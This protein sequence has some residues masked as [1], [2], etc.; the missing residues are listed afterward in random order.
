MIKKMVCETNMCAGCN[1]C[2]ELCPTNAIKIHDNLESYNALI[3]PNQCIECNICH[4]HCPMKN[5]LEGQEPKQWYQGWANDCK[6]R[7]MGSSGGLATAIS[8]YFLKEGGV[9]YSCIL[10][11]GEFI[12]DCIEENQLGQ[13]S[14]SKYVKSNP[15]GI[16]KTIAS[17]LQKQ[18]KVLFVGLPCQ[19]AALKKY[20]NKKWQKDLYTID[21]ICHGT[22]SPKLLKN[23][24]DNYNLDIFTS[25]DIKFRDKQQF[26]L[27]YDD[28]SIEKEKVRD[29]YT[30]A[31]LNGLIYTENCYK[32]PY[33]TLKRVSDLTLGDSWGTNLS[34]IEQKKGISLVLSMT[35]KGDILLKNSNLFLTSVDLDKAILNNDQLQEPSK[36]PVKRREFFRKLNTKNFNHLVFKL[37]PNQCIKQFIKVILIKLHLI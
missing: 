19:V 7:A 8:K 20:I 6:V 32:C 12:F 17:Q 33:A 22:P 15:Y 11:D 21:L 23:F 30:I 24:L 13:S 14:G 35:N 3:D 25:K 28:S 26:Q 10:Q 29:S 27:Y 16:Y 2:V 36:E 31:F 37:F 1:L 4:T 5:I 18:T 34:E 9:V